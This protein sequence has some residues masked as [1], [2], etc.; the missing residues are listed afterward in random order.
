M[1]LVVIAVISTVGLWIFLRLAPG[2][3]LV[4]HPNARSLHSAPTVVSGGVV[5]MALLALSVAMTLELP[6]GLAVS[7][8]MAGLV[9]IGL[10]DD[11]WGISSGVRL[12]GYLAAGIALPWVLFA[13]AFTHLALLLGLGVGVAWCINLV[14]FMDGA[15]GFA[16]TQAV[17]VATGL[18]LISVFGGMP[19]ADLSWLC[20]L[21]LVCCAPMLWFNWP[22]A[23]MFMGDAGA[24][25]LGFFLALLGLVAAATDP[26]VGAAWLIL[27]MPFLIDASVTL[28]IRSLSG[29]AP[30]VAHRDHAYQRLTLLTGGPLTVTLG[31]LAMQVVWQFPL[32]V[33]AVSSEVFPV[34]LVLLSAIPSIV[35]VVYA[36]RRA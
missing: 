7:M 3:G 16:T 35:A 28:C 9:V 34:L 21:L 14:N 12:A 6:G 10:V 8:I 29:E 1:I 5:P 20:A 23:K 17:C 18:G 15:D 26:R 11:R 36:R 19:N 2:L 27:M 22:P 32:A 30:H 4:D 13:D 31:L 25:P 24:I 33:T